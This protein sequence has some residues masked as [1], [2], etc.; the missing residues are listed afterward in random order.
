MV[1]L[2]DLAFKDIEAKLTEENITT[3]TFSGFAAQHSEVMAMGWKH[4]GADMKTET[5]MTS[6]LELIKGMAEGGTAHRADALRFGMYNALRQKGPSDGRLALLKCVN[7]K[8]KGPV[9]PVTYRSLGG[10]IQCA[11]CRTVNMECSVCGHARRDHCTW[12][13]GCR[14]LFG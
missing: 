1:K 6:T 7:E 4:L 3:E 14:M 11:K 13:K 10:K 8:C 5:T 12:C 2:K 9:Q